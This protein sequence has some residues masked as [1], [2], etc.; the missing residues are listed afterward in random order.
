MTASSLTPARAIR[1]PRQIDLRAV[2]SLLVTMAAIGGMLLYANSFAATRPLLIATRDLPAGA[3][4]NAADLEV[5]QVRV[6]DRIF[7][8][9][10]PG[11]AL[12]DV[13]GRPLADPV[14]APQI[15]VRAQVSGRPRLAPDQLALTIPVSAASAA[16]GQLREG[17]EVQVLLTRNEGKPDSETTVVLE[18]VRIYGIGYD[19]RA[20]LRPAS[21]PSTPGTL[22]WLTLIVTDE[23]ARILANARHSGELDV[24]L[25]PPAPPTPSAIP[26]AGGR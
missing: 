16:G 6:D 1:R 19:E 12:G 24:A 5:A 20:A 11:D 15:L 21:E 23:Q 13:L 14:H 4:L 9:A 2:L 8:A 22:A 25:L 17:D 26:T 3:I 10:V 7:A 18:R